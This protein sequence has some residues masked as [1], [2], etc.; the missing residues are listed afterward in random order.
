MNTIISSACTTGTVRDE[1]AHIRGTGQSNRI[2]LE[3]LRYLSEAGARIEIRIPVIP[4]YNTDEKT[5]TETAAFLRTIR[6]SGVRLLPYHDFARSKYQALGRA[7]TMPDAERPTEE[8]LGE[9]R[10]IL[11]EIPLCL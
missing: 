3:N 9:Y 4:G 8:L 2:I 7:D 10:K 5:M 1:T 11:G 6:V